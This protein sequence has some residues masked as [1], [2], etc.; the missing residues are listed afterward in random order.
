VQKIVESVR[1][2]KQRLAPARVG[3]GTG[4]SYVNVNRNIIDPRTRQWWEGPNY[5]GTSDKTVA[6]VRFETLAGAP[7][8][9][10]Y[11]YAVHGVLTGTLDKISGD[12][13]GATSRY[14]EDS[15]GGNAV[16]LFSAGTLASSS[17]AR[18]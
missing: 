15:L 16:A 6:V 3:Y 13:H 2:A 1:L 7:I 12:I 17:R 9:V 18:E 11:N 5:E 4:V 10:Y 14:I 8:A